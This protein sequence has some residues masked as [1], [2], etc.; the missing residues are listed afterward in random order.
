MSH[1]TLKYCLVKY[2]RF[3]LAS[4]RLNTETS[5][6]CFEGLAV[7]PVDVMED[8]HFVRRVDSWLVV[9]LEFRRQYLILVC[10]GIQV[11]RVWQRANNVL[12]L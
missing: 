10:A 4:I 8:G 6:E 3:K 9:R 5:H 12:N 11:I 1:C 7:F 2:Q